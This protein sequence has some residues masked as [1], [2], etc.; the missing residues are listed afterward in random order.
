[1]GWQGIGKEKYHD[2]MICIT[3]SPGDLGGRYWR[4]R[5]HVEILWGSQDL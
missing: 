5:W 2:V 1:M 3:R 4:A